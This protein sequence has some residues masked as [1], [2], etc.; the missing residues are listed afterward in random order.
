MIPD[1]GA[2]TSDSAL[3]AARATVKPEPVCV[4]TRD[5]TNPLILHEPVYFNPHQH[6]NCRSLPQHGEVNITGETP[7]PLALPHAAV[8][9]CMC[10]GRRG[11]MI[12]SG[13][14]DAYLTGVYADVIERA[15]RH[16]VR[17]IEQLLH[18]CLDGDG[19]D[20]RP[21]LRA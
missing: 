17:E 16:H 3:P 1:S 4:R 10:C 20:D 18:A 11:I 9:M 2:G 15:P 14:E 6:G 21:E 12:D 5:L 19:T 7:P 13:W 8:V